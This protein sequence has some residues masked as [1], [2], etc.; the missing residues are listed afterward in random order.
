[1]ILCVLSCSRFSPSY[2]LEMTRLGLHSTLDIQKWHCPHDWREMDETP[3]F[4]RPAEQNGLCEFCVSIK[5][6]TKVVLGKVS[7][8]LGVVC[9]RISNKINLQRE[10]L[11]LVQWR[12]QSKVSWSYCFRVGGQA[13]YH[14]RPHDKG[15]CLLHRGWEVTGGKERRGWDL[16]ILFRT[17]CQWQS[18]L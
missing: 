1:M 3:G 6:A 9:I 17:V 5:I 12:F 8:E 16:H 10:K 15:G 2:P 18:Q 7:L 11:T 14:E 13:V 4:L